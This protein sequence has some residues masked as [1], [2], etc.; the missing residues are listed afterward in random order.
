[1]RASPGEMART[2]TMAIPTSG[3]STEINSRQMTAKLLMTVHVQPAARSI[4]R[5]YSSP[6]TMTAVPTITTLAA[7]H[8]SDKHRMASL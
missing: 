3:G 1:M 4:A 6:G 5:P 8:R 7:M 2:A